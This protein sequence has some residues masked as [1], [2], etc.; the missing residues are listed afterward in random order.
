MQKMKGQA[1]FQPDQTGFTATL[2]FP[3]LREEGESN[4]A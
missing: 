3:P 4:E 2:Q 1:G